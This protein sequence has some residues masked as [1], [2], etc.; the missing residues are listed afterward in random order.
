MDLFVTDQQGRTI[1]RVRS[2]AMDMAFGA[3][4]ND[5]DLSLGE[6]C[7]GIG[8]GS[9]VFVPGT[10]Y[11]GII[12]KLKPNRTKYGDGIEYSGQTWSG[13]LDDHVIEPPSGSAYRTMSG[14]ANK[15]LGQI[16]D[17]LGLSGTFSAESY[18]G[19]QVSHSFR[20]TSAYS[21]VVDMLSEAGA[22]LRMAWDT[23][24]R[25]CVLSAVKAKDWGDVPGVSG[26]TAYSAELDYRPYNHLIA[27]GKGEGTARAVYNLYSDAKGNLSEHKSMAGLDE[28]TYVYDYSNAEMEDLKV[29]AA[30]KLAKLRQ[31]NSIDVDMDSTAGVAVGDTVTAYSPTAGI[32]T[33]GTVTKLTVKVK[34][35]HATVTPGF[36]ARADKVDYS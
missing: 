33:T 19:I 32:A 13:V 22:R 17:L 3:D 27:L 4:E 25:R 11:G 16:V 2:F 12:G 34:D 6:R 31:T 26:S 36:E 14:D 29:K 24:A 8:A 23:K 30:E 18:S 28:R 9:L 1:A 10:E 21:G 35:G 15:V 20:Y 5:F 7:E